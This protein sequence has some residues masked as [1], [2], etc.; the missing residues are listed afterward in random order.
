MARPLPPR[1][2]LRGKCTHGIRETRRMY[3]V[4]QR[5][6]TPLRA[7][8]VTAWPPRW[9]TGPQSQLERWNGPRAAACYYWEGR[10]CSISS[11]SA[12]TRS[13]ACT[14]CR[15]E[16][17]GEGVVCAGQGAR[18]AAGDCARLLPPGGPPA[19]LRAFCA[20]GIG[21]DMH[22]IPGHAVAP[23][24]ARSTHDGCWKTSWSCAGQLLVESA[25]ASPWSLPM[26]GKVLS[27]DGGAIGVV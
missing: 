14:T 27:D 24:A 21:G 2:F 19:P 16:R 11:I 18:R 17:D 4:A 26:V 23:C 25:G 9:T 20:H 5:L 8:L 3:Q 7:L 15:D 22:D 12:C 1:P 6:H 10:R 13:C